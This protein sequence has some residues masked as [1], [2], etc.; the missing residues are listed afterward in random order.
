MDLVGKDELVH[1]DFVAVQETHLSTPRA[2]DLRPP[3]LA[4]PRVRRH[5]RGGRHAWPRRLALPGPQAAWG[6]PLP[7]RRPSQRRAHPWPRRHPASRRL[8]AR[9]DLVGQRVP[10]H[11]RGSV[12]RQHGHTGG[13]A[14]SGPG[15]RPAVHHL[16]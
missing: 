15:G 9:R 13:R 3:G 11:G 10:A 1:C 5:R 12:G 4:C 14:E 7:R 16:R 6:C 2:A 8:H